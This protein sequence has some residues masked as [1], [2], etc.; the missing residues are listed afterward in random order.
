M[1]SNKDL[2][3]EELKRIEEDIKRA[4]DKPQDSRPAQDILRDLGNL[5]KD[6]EKD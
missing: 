2:D 6:K 5:K 4:L 1:G 3:E